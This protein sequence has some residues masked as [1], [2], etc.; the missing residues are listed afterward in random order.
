VANLRPFAVLSSAPQKS[1]RASEP[2]VCPGP[3]DVVLASLA[4]Q[5]RETQ[6]SRPVNNLFLWPILYEVKVNP[7]MLDHVGSITGS[8]A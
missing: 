1:V 2:N 6:C 7:A 8:T 5:Y 3:G 4:P